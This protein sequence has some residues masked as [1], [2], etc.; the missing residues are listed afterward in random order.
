MGGEIKKEE[1]DVI[2][3]GALSVG[4]QSV[5]QI[6]PLG[7]LI[8]LVFKDSFLKTHQELE[9]IN[10]N[11][12]KA[13]RDGSKISEDQKKAL[14]KLHKSSKE[15]VE[16]LHS[17]SQENKKGLETF[18]SIGKTTANLFAKA[19]SK[20][21]KEVV[22]LSNTFRDIE[23]AGV[24]V[25]DGFQSLFDTARNTGMSMSELAGHLKSSAPLIAKL[26]NSVG[27]GVNIFKESLSKISNEYNLTR[28]EEVAAFS[29]TLE[30]LT[31]SQLKQMKEE[32]LIKRVDETARQLKLLSLATGKTVEQIKEEQ[33]IKAQ[34]MRAQVFQRTNKDAYNMLQQLGLDSTEM[35]DYIAS[36]GTRI[37]PEIAMQL[38]GDELLRTVLPKIIQLQ[39]SGNLNVDTVGQLQNQYGYLADR[40]MAQTSSNVNNQAL[41]AAMSASPL[42][43][44]YAANDAF[45]NTFSSM[46]F[47]K[48]QSSMANP[49]E[50]RKSSNELLTKSEQLS[51][52][53]N[54][55]NTSLLELK[56]GG[57]EGMKLTIN[58][59]NN[60]GD[61]AEGLVERLGK[62]ASDNGAM[63]GGLLGSILT[64][65]AGMIG[66]FAIARS[67]GGV[68]SIGGLFKG[69]KSGV[70]RRKS[71]GS[72]P[73]GKGKRGSSA[74]TQPRDA[75]G[76]FVK[77]SKPKI[78]PTKISKLSKLSK[79]A[80]KKGL[81][82]L[83]KFAGKAGL[84]ALPLA[85]LVMGAGDA[86]MRA[87]EGDWKGATLEALAG[88]ASTIPVAGTLLSTGLTAV[89]MARDVMIENEKASAE[90]NNPKPSPIEE[91]EIVEENTV[92]RK[93][94]K[95]QEVTIELLK[96]IS[97]NI[98]I[99]SQEIQL[100]RSDVKLSGS[101]TNDRNS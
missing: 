2:T 13:L 59:L 92:A 49:S 58:Q 23:S 9:N 51:Q 33:N 101:R 30:H 37:T 78:K 71:T 18:I 94:E 89:S 25:E 36:G 66:D 6:K 63:G 70:K 20:N 4:F 90:L 74:K 61:A 47:G 60:V 16:K 83:A 88:V 87:R 50:G 53:V 14:E 85:G 38:A 41:Y 91:N 32:D 64:A 3:G 31:P 44:Q 77:Q 96:N 98:E 1:F 100:M 29:A 39:R 17:I 97:E 15:T 67:L 43:E 62:L 22:D 93:R 7:D 52:T 8:R 46:N 99:I 5:E 80:K 73:K 72:K 21:V 65:G 28:S 19:L 54:N 26:N 42:Y 11:Q 95:T 76:R 82:A 86:I 79:V 81:G 69:K 48:L 57:V 10:K 24:Y 68:K 55:I 84:K 27:N 56:T 35:I 12:T 40:R 75:K 34:T 45:A